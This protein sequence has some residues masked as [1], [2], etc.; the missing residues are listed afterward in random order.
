MEFTTDKEL[1]VYIKGLGGTLWLVGGAVRDEMLGLACSDNDY[2]ITGVDIS[3]LPFERIAG[4]TFPVFLVKIGGE[5]CEVAMARKER[6]N[7]VGHKGF[8]FF[9][10]KSVSV[11]D[12][13]ARRDFTIN[14]MAINVITGELHDPFGGEVDL[15][16]YKVIR[17]TSV[18]FKEDPLRVFRAARFSAKL[19]FYIDCGT[20]SAMESLRDEIPS[21]PGERVWNETIKALNTASPS[22]YFR[23]LHETRCLGHWFKELDAL[24]VPD[25]HDGTAFDH[26]MKVMDH[27]RT[28]LERFGLLVHDL[29]KGLTPAENHPSHHGHDQLGVQAVNDLCDRLKVPNEYRNMGVL[30][31]RDHMRCKR[32]TEMRP[33]KFFRMCVDTG[34]YFDDLM[35]VSRIDS[36]FRD[37]GD[38]NAEQEYFNKVM[39]M[40]RCAFAVEYDITG[41]HIINEGYEPGPKIGEMLL[42]RRIHEYKRRITA[43]NT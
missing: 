30:C 4:S 40:A 29:G 2:L 19:G 7:G 11:K 42:C 6:K 10:D 3:A 9:A 23:A 34:T 18:A 38:V 43:T 5:Y 36:S 12:D 13:L 17:Q 14:S 8:E 20:M 22:K 37:G 21:L 35:H 15:H 24:H 27:G 41:M 1:A 31:A 39:L 32:A 28:P 25:K 26:T 33:G 16:I